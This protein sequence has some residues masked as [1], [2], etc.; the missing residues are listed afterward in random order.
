MSPI[1]GSPIDSHVNILFLN[2][3]FSKMAN[4]HELSYLY[5]FLNTFSYNFYIVTFVAFCCYFLNTMIYFTVRI[6]PHLFFL[7]FHIFYLKYIQ[8]LFRF[9]HPYIISKRFL[10]ASYLIFMNI[11]NLT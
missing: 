6:F 3:F 2:I 4:F 9:Y 7:I 8:R 10:I 1:V 11:N 5:V